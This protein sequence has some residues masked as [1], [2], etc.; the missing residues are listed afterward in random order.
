[1]LKCSPARHNYQTKY[2]TNGDHNSPR[3]RVFNQAEP[4][5]WRHPRRIKRNHL[6][7]FPDQKANDRA[8]PVTNLVRGG[9]AGI[10][11]RPCA[12]P[13]AL[14]FLLS[15]LVLRPSRPPPFFPPFNPSLFASA[16]VSPSSLLR[17]VESP[18]DVPSS[19]SQSSALLQLSSPCAPTA[20]TCCICA[21]HGN[22]RLVDG[23]EEEE[24][25]EAAATVSRAGEL[26]NYPN[27]QDST[28]PAWSRR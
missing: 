7:P 9:R 27:D 15:L 26:V 13:P 4:W 12:L 6:V 18:P 10:R 28:W 22:R 17:R 21:V 14:P 23:E 8:F 1:M 11:T 19:G 5:K 25:E 24:E 2:K 20:F 3:P 16:S